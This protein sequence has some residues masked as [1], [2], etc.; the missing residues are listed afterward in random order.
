M[1]R[2]GGGPGEDPEKNKLR[3]PVFG[4]HI[5]Q[6]AADTPSN[7]RRWLGAE[8]ANQLLTNSPRVQVMNMWRPL[9]PVQRDALAVIDAHSMGEDEIVEVPVVFPDHTFSQCEISYRNADRHRWHYKRAM[10][11]EDVLVF[12]QDDTT[13]RPGAPR[14]VAHVA[15]RDPAAEEDGKEA[16][17]SIELRALV[18]YDED[19]EE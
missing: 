14:R 3:G 4:V 18:F 6:T 19:L 16:R 8:K 11:P 17:S 15:F 9:R 7:A 13:G 1:I 12:V 5:D 2:T 10:G